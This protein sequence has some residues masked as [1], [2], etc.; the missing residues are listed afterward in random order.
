MIGT[1]TRFSKIFPWTWQ[2]LKL[3]KE[4]NNDYQYLWLNSTCLLRSCSGVP[5][6]WTPL[7]H[8]KSVR[9]MEMSA[10]KRV[11]LKIRSPHMETKLIILVTAIKVKSKFFQFN[12]FHDLRSWTRKK[13]SLKLNF[14]TSLHWYSANHK[15]L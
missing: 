7:V 1:I 12:R 5:I 10:L 4:I 15:R 13:R 9:F 3:N 2:F 14:T 8:D 6:K 11:H